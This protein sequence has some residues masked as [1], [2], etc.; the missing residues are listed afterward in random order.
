MVG[1]GGA[2]LTGTLTHLLPAAQGS[3]RLP[4]LGHLPPML[5]PRGSRSPLRRSFPQNNSPR[6]FRGVCVSHAVTSMAGAAEV[7]RL[8]RPARPMARGPKALAAPP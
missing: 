5:P 8:R 7:R 6:A 4:N 1:N 3:S 2:L